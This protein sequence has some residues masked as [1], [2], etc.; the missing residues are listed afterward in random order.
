MTLEEINALP[1]VKCYHVSWKC[2]S[3]EYSNTFSS[4]AERDK[5]AANVTAAPE[6]SHIRTWESDV[7]DFSKVE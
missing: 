3:A 7:I 5:F 2:Y 4:A 6:C 1:K